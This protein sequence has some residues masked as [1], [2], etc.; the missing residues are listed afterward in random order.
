M[1]PLP[2]LVFLNLLRRWEDIA[3]PALLGLLEKERLERYLQED[4]V[5]IVDYN[6]KAH[7]VHLTTHE[8]RGFIGTCTYQLRG[9]DEKPGADTSLTLRQQIYLLAQLAFYTGIGY[10][11]SMGLGQSRIVSV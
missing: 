2:E 8:Q 5:I 3:P 1:V 4:G 11:T 6:L 10:K 7:H 9:H